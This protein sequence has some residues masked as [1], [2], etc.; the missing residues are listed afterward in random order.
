MRIP[1]LMTC[2]AAALGAAQAQQSASYSEAF[3][4][5]ERARL[6]TERAEAT[7]RYGEE[8]ADCYQRFA[9]NDCLRDLRRRHRV[10]LEELRR[11][12]II[13]NDARRAAL[14]ARRQQE[15]DAR[16]AKRQAQPEMSQP[17]PA[18]SVPNP[19]VPSPSV[20]VRRQEAQRAYDEKQREARKNREDRERAK[21]EQGRRTGKPLPVPP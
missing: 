1:I 4:A 19:P 2:L 11:Q 16:A 18:A 17:A 7:R 14:A 21:A 10:N 13:L 5:R 9:V 20:D 8:E 15:I 6:A 3:D 12:E